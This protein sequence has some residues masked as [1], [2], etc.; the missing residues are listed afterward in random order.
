MSDKA[1]GCFLGLAIGDAMGAPVEFSPPGSF[2]P[3]TNYQ[4]GG[5]F[6]LQAGQY[7]DDS[8]MALCL[9]ESLLSCGGTNLQDQMTRYWDWFDNGSNS[10]TGRCFDIGNGT[11]NALLR[12]RESG[13]PLSGA[14]D[15]LGNGS[16]MRLAP[17]AIRYWSDGIK[18][19]KYAI[20]STLTTHGHPVTWAAT[21]YL[22][23]ALSRLIQGSSKE[24]VMETTRSNSPEISQ[25]LSGSWE[26]RSV[27][28]SGHVLKSL[29]AALWAFFTTDSF[30]DCVLRAVN[31]GDDAD[32]V[33]AIAG[34]LAGA[35]YGVNGIPTE[36]VSGLQDSEKFQTLAER[37]YGAAEGKVA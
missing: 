36:W 8:S 14:D 4:S 16:L 11:R 3:V 7:T 9:A 29:E 1:Q 25:V 10:S 35:C 18:A 31:L 28:A 6:N 30:A 26:G 13:D 34:Q 33:G 24:D 37:L 20:E 22:A 21:E 23:D 15:A 12:W 17:V 19:R 32:S 5:P 27:K 2:T